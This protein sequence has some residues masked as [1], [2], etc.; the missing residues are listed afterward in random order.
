MTAVKNYVENG[1]QATGYLKQ[2]VGYISTS[3]INGGYGFSCIVEGLTTANKGDSLIAV[4]YMKYVKDG[5]TKYEYYSAAQ[6]VS[7]GTLYNDYVDLAFPA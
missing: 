1:V 2:S 7:I 4:G 3:L 6:S 5:Q